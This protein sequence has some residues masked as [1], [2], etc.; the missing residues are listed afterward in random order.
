L[1][2]FLGELKYGF[3]KNEEG[4]GLCLGH[5]GH[6]IQPPKSS[7]PTTGHIHRGEQP[8]I[9]SRP[10]AGSERHC[11]KYLFIHT[12]IYNYIYILWCIENSPLEPPL[13]A[14]T[15]SF[16]FRSIPLSEAACSVALTF[17][18]QVASLLFSR[19]DWLRSASVGS[20]FRKGDEKS[21]E[22]LGLYVFI[23]I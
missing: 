11:T 13:L 2:T 5:T 9:T 18:L 21:Q 8:K 12:H 14:Y 7:H 16:D 15:P 17:G 4:D 22:L 1:C 19:C 23:R 20:G 6:T 10:H 3:E